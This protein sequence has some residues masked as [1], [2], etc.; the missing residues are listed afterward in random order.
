MNRSKDFHKKEDGVVV[1]RNTKDYRRAKN[2]NFV[3]KEQNK[4]FGMNGDEGKIAKLERQLKEKDK[5]I[6]SMKEDIKTLKLFLNSSN[7]KRG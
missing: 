2:R 6:E 7:I 1:N 4:L 3:R 5:D